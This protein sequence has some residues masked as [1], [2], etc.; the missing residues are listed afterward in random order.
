[1]SS[2]ACELYTNDFLLDD[3]CIVGFDE[4]M[5]TFFFLSGDENELGAPLIWLGS[6]YQ[7]FRTISCI[8]AYFEQSGVEIR[9]SAE[10]MA[11]LKKNDYSKII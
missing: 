5:E 11:E 1:M 2:Y 7:Q 9:I 6:S 4:P 3:N 10:D 8:I